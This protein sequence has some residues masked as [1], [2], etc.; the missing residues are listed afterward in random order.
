VG[1][2]PDL[3]QLGDDLVAAARRTTRG[4][5]ARRRCF[6][7][8]TA[9]TGALAF[10]ALTPPALDPPDRE[11]TIVAAAERLAPPTCDH[12]RGARYTLA[13]CQ[14]PMVLHRP[15]AIN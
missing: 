10:A 3:V 14:G 9:V 11:F 6:L 4:R 15:Y 13:A 2:P 12:T 5:R 7:A 1:L 8:A